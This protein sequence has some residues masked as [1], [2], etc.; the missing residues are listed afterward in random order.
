[1]LPKISTAPATE[2]SG[3][4]RARLPGERARCSRCNAIGLTTPMCAAEAS[5]G[6]KDGICICAL[7]AA[8]FFFIG[9]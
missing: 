5:A 9:L 8:Y 6:S 2:S 3:M 4:A 1:M 7:P